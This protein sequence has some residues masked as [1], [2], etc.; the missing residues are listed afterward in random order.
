VQNIGAKDQLVFKY[1]S[2]DPNTDVSGADFVSGSNL[3][4]ADLRYHTI[5]LGI[6]HHWD[7]NVK[8]VLYYEI[9]RNETVTTAAGSSLSAY[10]GDVRDNVLTFRTQYR[11]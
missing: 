2:Y 4:A 5:G 1:D 3:G 8:F 9:V 10:T 11:F 7:E 6:V